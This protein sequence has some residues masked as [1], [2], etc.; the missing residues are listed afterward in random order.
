MTRF[1]PCIGLHHG[2]VKQ[3]VGGTL[4]DDGAGLRTN[5]V[6]T[7]SAGHYAAMY[8]RDG[9]TGAHVIQL[10][11]DNEAASREALAA[12]PGGLQIGGGIR[13]DNAAA[14]LAAGASV[15]VIVTSAL[16]DAS[17]KFLPD[18]PEAFSRRVTPAKL[19]IDLS[20]RRDARGWV[21][22]MNKW[23]TPTDMRLDLATLDRSRR[24]APSSSSTPPTSKAGWAVWTRN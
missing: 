16:F 11:P 14:W 6:S 13:I 21:V 20:C 3:I 2:R 15:S 4:T 8:R 10:G 24:I 9:L 17:G 12:W 23:R 18:M 7:H 22:A 5:F 19:V 1:R